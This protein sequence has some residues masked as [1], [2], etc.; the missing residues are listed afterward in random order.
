MVRIPASRFITSICVS[1]ILSVK[2]IGLKWKDSW[3]PLRCNALLNAPSM[4][5][6]TLLTGDLNNLISLSIVLA[7]KLLV[8]TIPAIDGGQLYPF[9][10]ML[11]QSNNKL[12]KSASRVLRLILETCPPFTA[13]I[14]R[15]DFDLAAMDNLPIS[16][17]K[18]L[19]FMSLSKDNTALGS[20]PLFLKKSLLYFKDSNNNDNANPIVS[21][22][23]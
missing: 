9:K 22:R 1:S 4:V 7:D 19:S 3:K 6:A 14:P 10:I 13:N 17:M 11:R 2:S 5:S 21:I 15:P 18:S 8:S 23:D 12:V 20:R 16:F